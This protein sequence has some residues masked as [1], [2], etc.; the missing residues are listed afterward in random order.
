[1]LRLSAVLLAAAIISGCASM[2]RNQ[3]LSANWYAIGME[4]GA[5]GQPLERLGTH[6]RACAEH[7][8]A[9]DAERYVAGRNEGLKSF[10]TYQRGFSQGRAGQGYAG[11]CPANLAAGFQ[12]GYQLGRELYDLH[13]RLNETQNQI[14]RSKAL[15]KDGIPNPRQRAVEVERLEDLTRESEQLE[16]SIARLESR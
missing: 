5:R 9:P 7:G 11:S 1:M 10:C 2:D 3:C 4:D 13:R 8:V 12:S 15:L 14:A 6:R 16:T